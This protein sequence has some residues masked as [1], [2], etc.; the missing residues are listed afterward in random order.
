MR[1]FIDKPNEFKFFAD[2]NGL[3]S[4]EA[5]D[6]GL[7]VNKYGTDGLAKAEADVTAKEKEKSDAIAKNKLEEEKKAAAEK[8]DADAKIAAAATKAATEKEEKITARMNVYKTEYE[9]KVKKEAADKKE[10]NNAIETL[11]WS[12]NLAGNKDWDEDF[13]YE[14]LHAVMAGGIDSYTEPQ[15]NAAKTLLDPKHKNRLAELDTNN[16]Q[17]ENDFES[18]RMGNL[19]NYRNTHLD[20]QE[21]EAKTEL[22]AKGIKELTSAELRAKAIKE[23]QEEGAISKN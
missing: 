23:L 10:F 12:N 18:F 7:Y 8:A 19:K 13:D 14:Y 2:E 1:R 5:L 22:A 21:A 3:V 20:N 17:E 11:F 15:K 9:E 4:K 16:S 6:R